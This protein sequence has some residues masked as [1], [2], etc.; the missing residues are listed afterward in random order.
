MFDQLK[1]V[2]HT[3]GPTSVL[4]RPTLDSRGTFVNRS[5]CGSPKSLETSL[6]HKDSFKKDFRELKHMLKKMRADEEKMRYYTMTNDI[7]AAE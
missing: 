1:T 5:I 7:E 2:K 6:M 4:M 3:R